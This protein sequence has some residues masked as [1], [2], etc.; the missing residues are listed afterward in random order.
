MTNLA[1]RAASAAASATGNDASR[2]D[3]SSSVGAEVTIGPGNGSASARLLAGS[4]PGVQAWTNTETQPTTST[5]TRATTR[6]HVHISP[7]L[8]GEAN[9][10]QGVYWL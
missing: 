8:Q 7:G 5:Q 9:S 1:N 2:G 6:P 10:L 4:F 3:Q